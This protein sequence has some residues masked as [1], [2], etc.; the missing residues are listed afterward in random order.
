MQLVN[1]W[2]Y[3]NE[4]IP[5]EVCEDIKN[6]SNDSFESATVDVHKGT[7]KEEREIGRKADYGLDKK[8]RVSDVSW[9]NEQW[10]YDVIWPYMVESNKNAGWNFDIKAADNMQITKY[11]KGGF[12]NWHKD[13]FSDCLSAYNDPD[14]ELFHGNVRKLSM[15]VLLND[16]YEGGEFQFAD[17]SVGKFKS[18]SPEV[19][20]M[21]SVIVFPSF[22]EHRVSSVTKGTRYSLVTWFLGPPFK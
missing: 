2:F 19:N 17:Y 18:V 16:D 8:V 9:T 15:T 22:M 20:K 4:V 13:G 11:S 7:T 21:G 3:F 1:E 5:K 6:L 10:V 12:Y 14:R